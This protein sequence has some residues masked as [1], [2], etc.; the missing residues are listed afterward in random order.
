MDLTRRRFLA[1]S[2][3]ACGA[4]ATAGMLSADGWLAPT[5]AYAG[6]GPAGESKVA[7]D[8]ERIACTYHQ[9]HCGGMC[10]L[11]CTVRDGRL[12][13]VEPNHC[14]DDRYETICLKGI[15]EVQH[16]YGSHRIQT[17]LR[18]VGER[19]ANEFEPISWD[20]AYDEIV[21]RLTSLQKQHGRDCVMVGATTEASFPFLAPMLG[22]Q[23]GGMGGID[24]GTG[25]GLD[26]AIGHGGGYA[27][28]TGEARDW[29]R[30]NMVLTVGS[31]F[32]E[33]TL[34]QVRLFF[35][36]KEAGAK[37]ITVDPHFSTTASKSNEWIPITPGTDIALLLGM[38]NVLIE[39]DLYDHEFVE[40]N[41]T[42]FEEFAA[43]V[44]QYTPSWA[45]KICDVP[46]DRIQELTR[47]MAKAAPPSRPA[48]VPSSAARTPTPSRPPASSPPSTRFW[49][50]GAPRAARCSPRR[51]R[52][53]RSRTPASPTRPSRISRAWATRNTR[54]PSTAPARTSPR[55][56]P[57]S[58]AP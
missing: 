20:E 24:N 28:A 5:K 15:S 32:C 55:C 18:R 52:P 45:E 53:A 16:I 57:R 41:T 33:S 43:E 21:E 6:I 23:T 2:L 36:A 46:A 49:A 3:A 13:K 31:N 38:A 19:G 42:G 40:Q 8:E 35:E 7:Y 25:N 26:P 34:P 51:R 58:T 39:E 11:R 9:E 50:P 27:Y 4:A 56:R 17:P 47:A 29:T 30:A 48:G 54:W 12:V 14:V 10:P 37:M 44:K 22:A 1:G